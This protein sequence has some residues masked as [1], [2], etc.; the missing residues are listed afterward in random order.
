MYLFGGV[1]LPVLLLCWPWLRETRRYAAQ[2]L[3]PRRESLVA[4]FGAFLALWRS[5]Y[6]LRVLAGASLWFAV[7]AWSSSCLFFFSYD[8]TNERQWTPAE[9]SHALTLAY[10]LAILATCR[11]CAADRSDG[12]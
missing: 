10:S 3:T 4:L 11:A 7:N 9:V 5:R 8:V 1:V 6:R 2:T 12:G